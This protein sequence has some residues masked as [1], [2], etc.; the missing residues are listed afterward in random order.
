MLIYNKLV[1]DNESFKYNFIHKNL[2]HIYM[3]QIKSEILVSYAAFF[4]GLITIFV[5]IIYRL[6]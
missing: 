5:P 1:V 3:P 6:K 4:I 2:H